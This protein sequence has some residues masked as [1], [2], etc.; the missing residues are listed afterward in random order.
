MKKEYIVFLILVVCSAMICASTLVITS[1]LTLIAESA[2]KAKLA[3]H[4]E[5]AAESGQTPKATASQVQT[6]GNRV[7]AA[8]LVVASTDSKAA[9]EVMLITPT[10]QEQIQNMLA[11][12]SASDQG[13]YKQL[14]KEFQNK[15]AL[16]PTG[17]MDTSTL[18]EIMRQ[19]ALM[20]TNE[21]LT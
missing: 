7:Q 1:N 5:T 21:A 15:H 19:V 8:A 20:K 14:L 6:T 2:Q 4:P 9:A 3:A 10:E 13:D 11:S 16:N 18:N 12:L 17:E